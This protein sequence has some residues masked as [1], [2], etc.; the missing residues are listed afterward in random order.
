VPARR[1]ANA[2][3]KMDAM[4]CTTGVTTAGGTATRGR[5]RRWAIDTPG[6]C[7][8]LEQRERVCAADVCRRSADPRTLVGAKRRGVT[9]PPIGTVAFLAVAWAGL[10]T[11]DATS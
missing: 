6:G 2:V 3:A 8:R 5:C 11:K 1:S 10:A 7:R 4:C 9:R